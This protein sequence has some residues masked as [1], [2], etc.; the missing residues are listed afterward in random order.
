MQTFT[1][2]VDIETN[3]WLIFGGLYDAPT[4]RLSLTISGSATEPG[5][6]VIRES[7]EGA[8][9]ASYMAGETSHGV[10]TGIL[11][12]R[13]L[14][15]NLQTIE[16]IVPSKPFRLEYDPSLYQ[17][18]PTSESELVGLS[19][20]SPDGE[21]CRIPH[22]L[23]KVL[24]AMKSGLEI[25]IGGFWEKAPSEEAESEAEGEAEDEAEGW[26]DE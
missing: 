19:F 26:E 4:R 5:A 25:S 24:L 3:G 12:E 2:G 6:Q 23:V 21:E 1:Y 7:V 10:V 22:S 20:L 17:T 14:V 9:G 13:H 15:I 8:I 16:G 11:I 18:L